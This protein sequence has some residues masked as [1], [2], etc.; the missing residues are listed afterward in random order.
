MKDNK[1]KTKILLVAAELFG[2][3]GKDAVSASDIATKA[4]VNK[5]LIF[6][7]FGSKDK[8]Y[9]SVIKLWIDNLIKSL[10]PVINDPSDGIK[11][12]EYFV[13]T[14]TSYLAKNQNMF[15]VLLREFANASNEHGEVLNYFSK[16]MSNIKDKML[17]TIS[18]AIASGEIRNVDPLQTMVNIISLDVF[19][20]LGK[21][22]LKILKPDGFGGEFENQRI[23][24]I[25]DM[26]M[27]GL[28]K[29]PE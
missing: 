8:L 15:R 2:K 6:Y 16:A 9:F 14:H 1:T 28:R 18:T 20:F 11:K 22:I 27:N 24:H 21:P 23:E 29:R 3:Y 13:R 17:D 10:E 5:A 12:I 7:Y 26:V 4:E 25:L 19:F